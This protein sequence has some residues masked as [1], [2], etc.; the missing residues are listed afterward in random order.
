MRTSTL[1]TTGLHRNHPS[2]DHFI[3][4]EMALRGRF[5]EVPEVLFYNRLH[6][7]AMSAERTRRGIAVLLDE[8]KRTKKP[9]LAPVKLARFYLYR[10][11]TYL[12]IIQD[13]RLSRPQR[14]RC[15][16]EV[17]YAVGRWLRRPGRGGY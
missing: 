17:A 12:R 10:V 7:G 1:A 11:I 16:L 5:A 4:C 3:L 6:P 13:A 8:K 15:R 9:R 14:R 2:N